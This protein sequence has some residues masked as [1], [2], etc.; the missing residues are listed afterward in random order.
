LNNLL[1]DDCGTVEFLGRDEELMI[2]PMTIRVAVEN[3]ATGTW[4]TPQM[5]LVQPAFAC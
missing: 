1:A 5:C 2:D 3:P 4:Q